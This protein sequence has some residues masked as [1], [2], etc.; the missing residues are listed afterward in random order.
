M[1]KYKIAKLLII[2]F[3]LLCTVTSLYYGDSLLLGSFSSF[4]ND[5]VKYLRSAETLIETGK[6]TYKDVNKSTVFIMPGIVFFLTPFVRLFGME[7]ATVFI[8]I[9]QAIIQGITLYL[10]FKIYLKLFNHKVALIGLILNIIYLPNIYI[11]TVILTETLFIFFLVSCIYFLIQAVNTKNKKTYFIAGVFWALATMFRAS[12]ALLPVVVFFVW[13]M[14][15]YAI[16]EMISFAIIALIPFLILFTPWWIRNYIQFDRFIPF[17]LSSGNPMLQG[18]FINNNVD[19]ELIAKLNDENLVYTN[20]EINNDIVE[21]K[22]ASKVFEYYLKNDT[23][24][25]I[26]WFLFGKTVNNVKSPYYG[27]LYGIKFET[28]RIVHLILVILSIIGMLKAKSKEKYLIIGLWIYFIVIHIPFLSYVRYLY[29]IMPLI[30]PM[31]GCCL[32]VGAS[33]TRPYSRGRRPRRPVLLR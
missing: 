16:K 5:D 3:I 32:N 31:V 6:L 28:V 12:I 26:K 30:I 18:V 27:E 9:S 2:F 23:E 13:L 22:M 33:I 7:G 20:D 14:H 17:T 19:Y 25:Y 15:K 11:T 24:N 1:K 10:I 4:D 8:R 29:P 21:R